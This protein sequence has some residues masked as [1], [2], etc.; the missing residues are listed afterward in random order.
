LVVANNGNSIVNKSKP[1]AYDA[2]YAKDS[3]ASGSLAEWDGKNWTVIERR[4][5]TDVTGPG[6][7]AGAPE[8]SSP[9]WAI[10]W[11][12]RSVL[13]KLLDSGKWS[14][15]RLPVAD[16]SYVA[17]HGWYTEWPRIREIGS[18]K[19]LMNMHGQ[20]FDFPKTFSAAQTGGI[21]PIG[22]CLKITG[23]FCGWNGRIV[24]GC[25]D[26][27]IMENPLAL[28]SQSNLWFSSWDNLSKCG[29]PSGF[30]GPWVNDDVKANEPSAPY[31]FSGYQQRMVHLSHESDKPVKFIFE[32]DAEG[33]G[34][35]T[36]Y[37]SVTV[38]PHGYAYHVFPPDLSAQWI[39]L[40]TD[41]NC[42][43]ATAYFHYGPGGGANEKRDPFAAIPD[44]SEKSAWTGGTIRPLGEDSGSLYFASRSI[45]GD[46][47]ASPEHDNVLN[48]KLQFDAYS[49]PA[50]TEP[51]TKGA[52]SDFE[53]GS[54]D[55]S[56]YVVQKGARY[57]L[58]VSQAEAD[59]IPQ[60]V[61]MRQLREVVTER[62][63][64]N[65]G[66]SF[67]DLP[68]TTAGGA[69]RIKPVCTHN[70][71]FTDF[72]SWRG[73]MV[74]AGTRADAKQDGH[75]FSAGD[76]KAGLWLGDIDDLWG[77]G[78]PIGHG[79]PWKAAAVQPGQPSDPYL[80]AGYDRKTIDLSH[81]AST[82]VR[83]TLEVD[84]LADGSWHAFQDF[85]VPAGKT[86]MYEFPPGYSAHWIRARCNT[87]CHATVLLTYE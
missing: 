25:D 65:A 11:D 28:Q 19:L 63:L 79:G 30:G 70:K 8:E 36:E 51:K 2:Q 69:A 57:R 45:E 38:G 12:K 1:A 31:L 43:G 59:S 37:E 27:S 4:Q 50:V 23:D 20:W 16:Y 41:S 56:A 17:R 29:R 14:D 35:W 81:D 13:L 10:G 49:G 3:E 83:F 47:K 55:A 52:A 22:D 66:G 40:R 62:F 82:S 7:I 26:A 18:G 77:L 6:G 67:F 24:F 5:F 80:M 58:P 76:G 85:E 61:A 53:V 71:R 48:P 9:L 60:G 74:I 87:A 33:R 75:Y 73:L 44:A 68:R 86:I 72:C 42:T 15:F 84:F 78:K 46:G 64:L 54:D 21:R 39:R 32:L 34:K